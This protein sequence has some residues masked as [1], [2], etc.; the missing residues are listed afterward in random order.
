MLWM[1]VGIFPMCS[2]KCV[3]TKDHS[4]EKPPDLTLAL[5]ECVGKGVCLKM[6]LLFKTD[7]R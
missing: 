3:M 4:T 6:T 1:R 5:S 7:A 2:L